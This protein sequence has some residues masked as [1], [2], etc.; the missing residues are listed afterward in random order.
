MW[1]VKLN[2]LISPPSDYFA[3]SIF[4]K[5]LL[6]FGAILNCAIVLHLSLY[7][8]WKPW[9]VV[10]VFWYV[11]KSHGWNFYFMSDVFNIFCRFVVDLSIES[12]L[13]YFPTRPHYRVLH[14]IS[15]KLYVELVH[16]FKGN[17]SLRLCH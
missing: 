14:V 10:V 4:W 11:L 17:N 12:F 8:L 16:V 6:Y 7:W 9:R 13:F 2:W 1:V 15:T 5:D 3:L